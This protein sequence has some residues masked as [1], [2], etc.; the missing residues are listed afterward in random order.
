MTMSLLFP[1]Q[2]CSAC[3]IETCM[4]IRIPKND[5]S[6]TLIG[7]D[8]HK[9]GLWAAMTTAT[10]GPA[11]MHCLRAQVGITHG[12]A[13]RCLPV[14]STLLATPPMVGRLNPSNLGHKPFLVAWACCP[15]PAFE[16]QKQ[17]ALATYPHRSSST[18]SIRRRSRLSTAAPEAIAVWAVSSILPRQWRVATGD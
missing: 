4:A 15:I 18:R 10:C 2:K 5:V 7:N 16:Q 13:A 12:V 14:L 1:C 3:S 6:I 9:L 17:R 11:G 8:V